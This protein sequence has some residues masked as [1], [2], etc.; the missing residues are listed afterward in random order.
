LW[1]SL[2]ARIAVFHSSTSS[3]PC[4]HVVHAWF[5]QY[6]YDFLSIVRS[7]LHHLF[8]YGDGLVPEQ[9]AS[10]A[11]FTQDVSRLAISLTS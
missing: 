3:L 8:I 2:F 10:R 7:S 6:V 5:L 11:L 1:K 9:Y 4:R